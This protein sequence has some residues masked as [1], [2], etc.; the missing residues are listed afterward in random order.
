MKGILH[1][2]AECYR[3]NGSRTGIT[4]LESSRVR[5]S[6]FV[7][8]EDPVLSSSVL[9]GQCFLRGKKA[10]ALANQARLHGKDRELFYGSIFLIGQIEGNDSRRRTAFAPL[11][12]YS[13]T[14]RMCS[15]S[16]GQSS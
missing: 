11:L 14:V 4:S 5:Q 12:L 15:E 10:A 3:E 16:Q 1:Y 6:V 2:L 13:A 7:T 8:G 9:G